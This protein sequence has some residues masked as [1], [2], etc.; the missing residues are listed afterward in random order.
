MK[1]LIKK[2]L[3]QEAAGISFDVRNWVEVLYPLIMELDSSESEIIVAG[4]DYPELFEAFPVDYFVID[5]NDWINGYLEKTSGIDENGYYVVHLS[6]LNRFKDNPYLKTIL[7]HELKHAYQDW[8]R[9]SK[10]YPGLGETKESKEFYTLDFIKVLTDKINVGYFFKNILKNYY[11]LS[12]LELNAFLENVYDKDKL[13]PY[14]NIVSGLRNYDALKSAQNENQNKL[15][16]DWET[17]L[18]LDIPFL[19]KH[20]TYQDFLNA[21]T[22]YF[23]QKADKIMRK[24]NKMEYVHRDRDLSENLLKEQMVCHLISPRGKGKGGYMSNEEALNMINKMQIEGRKEI[25]DPQIWAKFVETLSEFK[26][27][28]KNVDTNNDTVDTYLHK[29][30]ELLKCYNLDGD[31]DN[32]T[33]DFVF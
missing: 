21:S 5:F 9:Q 20:K 15:Q 16:S 25:H 19:K 18:T 30:R 1:N 2:I 27:N 14:K 4:E 6:I 17:L 32:S 23:N 3:L 12:D 31:I 28:I 13:N 24:I 22:K 8:Q 10:N 26:Q 11:L 29:L 7:N 33:K